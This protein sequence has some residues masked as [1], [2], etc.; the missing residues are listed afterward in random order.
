MKK[1]GI[2][3]LSLISV[4]FAKKEYIIEFSLGTTGPIIEFSIGFLGN[5]PTYLRTSKFGTIVIVG[6]KIVNN[7]GEMGSTAYFYHYDKYDIASNIGISNDGWFSRDVPLSFDSVVQN[8][9]HMSD[10][11]WTDTISWSDT[12]EYEAAFPINQTTYI[13]TSSSPSN[14]MVENFRDFWGSKVLYIQSRYGEW[15]KFRSVPTDNSHHF[16]L[17]YATT[18]NGQFP[19]INPPVDITPGEAVKIEGFKG[20]EEIRIYSSNGRLVHTFR[21]DYIT[22]NHA[23]SGLR[24]SAG[25]YFLKAKNLSR[26]IFVNEKSFL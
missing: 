8:E 18:I 23:L 1:I 22:M 15:I 14:I 6:D 10:G 2:I 5:T 3:L 4:L 19:D 7:P 21:S 24:L 25:I 11:F 13:Y 20:V 9:F 26:K 12:S 16:I 17:E